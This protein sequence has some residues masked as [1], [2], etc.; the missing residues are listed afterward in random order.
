MPTLCS[1]ERLT[2][3][4]LVLKRC[5]KMV[6]WRAWHDIGPGFGTGKTIES[7]FGLEVL[8]TSNVVSFNYG[9]PVVHTLQLTSSNSAPQGQKKLSI[10]G[11]ISA[12][13]AYAIL[14]CAVVSTTRVLVALQGVVLRMLLPLQTA[15]K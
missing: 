11:R 8:I 3:L 2:E 5:T 15:R 14:S 9:N 1:K 7:V 6:M 13:S 10:K 12:P 4:Q